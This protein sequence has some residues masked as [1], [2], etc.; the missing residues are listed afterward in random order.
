MESQGKPGSV[1]LPRLFTTEDA[2]QIRG[3]STETLTQWRIQRKGIPFLE[4]D[5]N[6][7]PIPTG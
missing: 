5:R 3:L 2:G 6:R 4:T 7:R 1:T